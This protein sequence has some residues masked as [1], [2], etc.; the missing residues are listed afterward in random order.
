MEVNGNLQIPVS[1][2]LSYDAKSASTPPVESGDVTKER[3]YLMKY[4]HK[5]PHNDSTSVSFSLKVLLI[6]GLLFLVIT[7]VIPSCIHITSELLDITTETGIAQCKESPCFTPSKIYVPISTPGF[8]SFLNY[9]HQGPLHVSYDKRSLKINDDRV[10]FLGGSMHPARTTR[11]TWNFALDEA[12]QNGLNLIT[13]YVMWSDHQPVR[14]K[15]INWTFSDWSS[16]HNGPCHDTDGDISCEE[17]NLAA[18][19]TSAAD[20]G[21]F[22]HLRVGPY[23]CAEYS[24][25]GIPEWLLLEKPNMRLRRPNFEWLESKY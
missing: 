21:L 6:T 18:A 17:W 4:G 16:P 3:Q 5:L 15:E 20:R 23:D 2:I 13:I 22:V 10:L 25:G 19:I 8:P 11:Q 7:N 14:N 1:Q 24:Y 12:V 9:A